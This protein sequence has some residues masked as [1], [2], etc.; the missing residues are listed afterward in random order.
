MAAVFNLRKGWKTPEGDSCQIYINFKL[1]YNNG[2]LKRILPVSLLDNQ[3]NMQK[4][5]RDLTSRK[6]SEIK[7]HTFGLLLKILGRFAQIFGQ[8]YTTGES[9][10][11]IHL[12]E[13]TDDGH[14]EEWDL[15]LP[16]IYVCVS[17]CVCV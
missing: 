2:T 17:V 8:G 1:P 3:F 9:Q 7:K 14:T 13:C 5:C 11:E 16:K 6:I 15:L 4:E 10:G 12:Q